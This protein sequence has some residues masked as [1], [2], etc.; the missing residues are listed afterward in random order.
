MRRKVAGAAVVGFAVLLLPGC[1]VVP[2]MPGGGPPASTAVPTPTLP[3]GARPVVSLTGDVPAPADGRPAAIVPAAETDLFPGAEG[4]VADDPAIWRDLEH[5]ERS[6]VLG[7]NKASDGGVGVF[8][9]GGHLKH[10]A[11]SGRIGNLDLRP[12][13]TLGGRSLIVV[14]ANDRDDA[15]L[16]LWSLDPAGPTLTPLA[17][18]HA[19]TMPD[20]YG[21]CLGRSSDGKHLYAMVTQENG[22][23][24]EQYELAARSGKVVATKVRTL[25]VGSQAEGCA[26]DD[27]TGAMYVSEEQKALW[28][29]DVDPASGSRRTAVDTVGGGHLAADVEGVAAVRDA[30]GNGVVVVSSQ[31]DSTYAVYDVDHGN[32]YRGSFRITRDGAVDGVTRTDGVAA[33]PG[34]FGPDFPNGLLVVHDGENH[35]EGSTDEAASDFKLVRLDRVATLSPR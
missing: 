1:G 31:G 32:R 7:G 28:R 22:G 24:L 5:P 10:Y 18:A 20:S 25:D 26:V 6:L 2:G 15:V 4:D 30:D 17:T 12:D 19:G 11:L 27:A 14:A 21:S 29:Y 33:V 16:R 34:S 23:R 3:D 35:D 9:L 13:V 8:D